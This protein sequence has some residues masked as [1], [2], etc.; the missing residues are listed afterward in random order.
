M[1]TIVLFF[2]NGTPDI[3][4]PSGGGAAPKCSVAPVMFICFVAALITGAWTLKG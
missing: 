2:I 4:M 3:M 1:L